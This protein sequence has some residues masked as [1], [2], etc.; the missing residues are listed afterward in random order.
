MA[1]IHG[2]RVERVAETLEALAGQG[3][4]VTAVDVADGRALLAT[5]HVSDE[6]VTADPV[7]DAD[8]LAAI[9]APKK[10]KPAGRKVAD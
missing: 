4:Y 9:A 5:H 6:G 7:S 10:P 2:C 8:V 1:S 3:E